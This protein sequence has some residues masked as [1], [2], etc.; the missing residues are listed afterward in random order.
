MIL[1]IRNNDLRP[2]GGA[3]DLYTL[4]TGAVYA[5]S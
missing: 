2:P 4:L 1:I 5:L 3:S